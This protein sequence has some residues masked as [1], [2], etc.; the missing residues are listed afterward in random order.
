MVAEPGGKSFSS[1]GMVAAFFSTFSG[2][3]C[4]TSRFLQMPLELLVMQQFY[5]VTGFQSNGF[6]HRS[7]SQLST[8]QILQLL[9]LD[10]DICRQ[11]N[12]TS[13]CFWVLPLLLGKFMPLSNTASWIS[14]LRTIAYLDQLSASEDVLIL[15]HCHLTN[16]LPAFIHKGLPFR[17]LVPSLLVGCLQLHRVL[18]GIKRHQGSNKCQR[19][20][21]T[22]EQMHIFFQ[23]LNFSDYNH[24][25][26]WAACCLGFLGILCAGEFTDNSHFNPDIH[27][28]VTDVHINLKYSTMVP[29]R[30]GCYI[31]IGAEKHN[32]CPMRPLTLYLHVHVHDSTSGPHF[33]LSEAPL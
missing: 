12:A 25:M 5:R 27:I 33:I 17:N 9:L 24:T 10:L 15:F 3:H 23:S 4:P 18:Q 20:P 21:I 13:M 2:L 14:V 8:T 26:L 22:I 1:L 32:L 29:F 30:Q 31:H 11:I 16:A 28:A 7:L 19:Q 6:L